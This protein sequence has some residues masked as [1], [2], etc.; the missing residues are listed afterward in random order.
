MKRPARDDARL[1]SVSFERTEETSTLGTFL[2][3]LRSGDREA[4]NRGWRLRNRRHPLE[5]R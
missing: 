2:Q 5:V 3:A 1:V 4:L